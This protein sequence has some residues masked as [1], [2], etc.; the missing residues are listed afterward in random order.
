MIPAAIAGTD[1]L[2]RLGP[3]RVAYGAPVELDDLR[4][5]E[6][7]EGAQIGTERL[8]AAIGELEATL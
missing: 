3:L 2:M 6:L 4:D 5:R 8:M 1:R 7:R